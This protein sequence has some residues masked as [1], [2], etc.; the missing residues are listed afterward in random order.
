MG[1]V[2]VDIPAFFPVTRRTGTLADATSA[3]SVFFLTGPVR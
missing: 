1:L 3:S 2:M